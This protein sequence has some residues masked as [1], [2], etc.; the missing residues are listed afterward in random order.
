MILGMCIK[1][2]YKVILLESGRKMNSLA[3]LLNGI[4]LRE[5]AVF[6]IIYAAHVFT[7]VKTN[8]FLLTVP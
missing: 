3:V 2:A 8:V 7:L 5:S 1:D 6:I 4:A